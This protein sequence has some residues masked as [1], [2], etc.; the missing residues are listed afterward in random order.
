[1]FSCLLSLFRNSGNEYQTK[2]HPKSTNLNRSILTSHRVS[3]FD[4]LTCKRARL[5]T[6]W[7]AMHM[8]ARSQKDPL[9]HRDTHTWEIVVRTWS[10]FGYP[11]NWYMA[12]FQWGHFPSLLILDQNHGSDKTYWCYVLQ[13]LIIEKFREVNVTQ[14]PQF[15]F[16]QMDKFGCK[17]R[18]YIPLKV[19]KSHQLCRIISIGHVLNTKCQ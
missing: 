15:Y 10:I 12:S 11:N 8:V 16:Q 6:T 13:K 2:K 1:M 14:R 19:Y 7:F 5:E 9:P 4:R 3:P 17:I 18:K